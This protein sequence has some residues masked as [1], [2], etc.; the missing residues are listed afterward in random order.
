MSGSTVAGTPEPVDYGR[1]AERLA[2][3]RGNPDPARRWDLYGVIHAEWG[4]VRTADELWDRPSDEPDE[5]ADEDEIASL[6][7]LELVP[8]ALREWWD[9]PQNSFTNSW[10]LYWTHPDWPPTWRPDPSGFGPAGAL[11]ADSPLVVDP[12]DL[13]LCNFMAEYQY[14]NEWAYRSA[15]ARLADP[16]VMVTAGAE[17]WIEQAASVSEFFL[18]MA[19]MRVV[20]AFGWQAVPDDETDELVERIRATMPELGLPP[21][22]ELESSTVLYGASDVIM[23]VD[24][25]GAADFPVMAVGRTREAV[26]RLVAAL[27][28][29]WSVSPPPKPATPTPN[30]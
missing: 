17:E 10:D 4:H 21:W 27:P 19:L 24:V 25:A 13:R 15:D 16:P 7:P 3:R 14:C 2:A 9:L 6:V 8:A 29:E 12:G 23:Y 30:Q 28:G 11:P 1:F 26:E 5:D 20:P 22:R 18:H